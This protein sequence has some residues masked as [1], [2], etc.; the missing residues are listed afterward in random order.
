MPPFMSLAQNVGLA[1]FT[2]GIE[3]IE[4]L[5]QPFF[6]RFSGIDGA[7]NPTSTKPQ[8]AER[9]TVKSNHNW[10]TQADFRQ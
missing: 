3:R 10:Q 7:T 1:G 5:L 2:L 8:M 9:H 6:R 4:G